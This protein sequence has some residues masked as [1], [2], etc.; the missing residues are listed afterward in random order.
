ML[1][2]IDIGNTSIVFGIFEGS[3][4]K[5]AFRIESSKELSVRGYASRIK[6]LFYSYSI[7]FKKI[8]GIVIAS[9]V[10]ELT[11][12]LHRGIK[13]LFKVPCMD[14]GLH[15]KTGITVDIEKPSELGAD[16]LA[17]AVAAY[18]KNKGF[19]I[20]VDFGTATSFDCISRE[21]AYIGGVIIPGP[22]LS[23]RALAHYTAQLP[24]VDI[25]VPRKIIGKNTIDCIE[26]GLYYGYR[27]MIR[28]LIAQLKREM[29]SRVF[30]FATGG[31]ARFWSRHIPEINRCIPH[32]TLEGLRI[33][34]ELNQW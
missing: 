22:Q 11:W 5:A 3:R 7:S 29:H 16:R 32:L 17:N 12:I 6:R 9:V 33:L 34:W 19:S 31:H 15:L 30:V 24:L 20:V 13:L 23:A 26:S 18:R 27:G 28:T 2:A 10:P 8:Q 25:R 14:V 21:G 4:L 1:L